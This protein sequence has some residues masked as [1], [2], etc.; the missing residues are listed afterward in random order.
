[1]AAGINYPASPS[2]KFDLDAL[3]YTDLAFIQA[4]EEKRL[5]AR[6]KA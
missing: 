3:R 6:W 5:R 1:M 4:E 2:E